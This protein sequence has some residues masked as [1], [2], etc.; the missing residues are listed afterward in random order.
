MKPLVKPSPA[1][2]PRPPENPPPPAE[3]FATPMW[4]VALT[5]LLCFWAAVYLDLNAGG[6]Q[7]LVFNH[8]D[9]PA[10]VAARVPKSETEGLVA[11][12]RRIYGVYCAACH[13][14][15]GRGRPGQFPPLAG[16]EWVNA[17]GVNRIIRVVLDGV[18]G[19]MTVR[20]QTFNNAMLPWRA[21]LSDE[22]IV[23]VLT[24]VRRNA[25]FH[26]TAGPVSPA[27]VKAVRDATQ[28]RRANWTEA[29]L[30]AVPVSQ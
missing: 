1:A 23:A 7:A 11:H 12:G 10:D 28:D 14:P 13:Q 25:E 29:E 3:Q 9:R 22:D 20:G 5:G 18:A 15:D 8:G 19:P 17:G 4:L 6:F 26:N 24:F 27:Q 21:H 2:T 30:L 16:S